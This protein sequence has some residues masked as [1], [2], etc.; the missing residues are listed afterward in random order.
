M[1]KKSTKNLQHI[2]VPHDMCRSH[3]LEPFDMLVYANI[4]RFMNKDTR[5][6]YPSIE[7][8]KAL[9][10][11]GKDKVNNSISKLQGKYLKIYNDGKRRTYVFSQRYKNFEPFSVDFLDKGDLTISEKS[12]IVAV[13]QYMFKDLRDLGK[14]SFTVREL[15]ELINMPEWEIWKCER[16]LQDKG[17]LTIIKTKDRDFDTGLQRTERI[18]NMKFLQQQVIW[19]LAQNLARIKANNAKILQLQKDLKNL[20]KANAQKDRDINRL[21]KIE[22]KHS[23]IF[24]KL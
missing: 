17:Y 14:V 11:S 15:S 3:E 19:T 20:R 4:K 23:D 16:S 2:Q 21:N 6:A 7:T 18:F 5:K 9:T 12:Y 8:L 13:Q 10:K 1:A 22:Y 24:M